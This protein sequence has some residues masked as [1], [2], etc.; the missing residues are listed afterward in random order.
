M[1]LASAAASAPAQEPATTPAAVAA[2]AAAPLTLDDVLRRVLATSPD[3]EAARRAVDAARAGVG[4]AAQI[5]NPDLTLEEAKETP[6]DAAT[7]SFPLE[8][9]GKRSERVHVAEAEA[10]VAEAELL[11]ATADARQAARR[12]FFGLAAAQR[13]AALRQEQLALATRVRDAA[14]ERYE[15]GDRPRLD[16]VEAQLVLAAAGAED[17]AARGDVEGARATLAVLLGE[18]ADAPLAVAADFAPAPLPPRQELA[19]AAMAT[20]G[21]VARLTREVEAQRS[22]VALARA[23][24]FPDLTVAGGV[25]HD[26][27]PDFLWGWRAALTVGVPLFHHNQ[28]QVEVEERTLAQREAELDAARRRVEGALASGIALVEATARTASRYRDEVLPQSQEV[29]SMAEDSYRSGETGVENL[30]A[31]LRAARDTRIQAIQAEL[32][33][34]NALADLEQVLGAPLP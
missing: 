28:H 26:S 18:P 10:R 19:T 23:E 12:A 30:L 33:Y 29:E 5:P 21:E 11:R 25:T 16:L 27:P 15:T 32:E 17:D 14:K 24:Q 9:G 2:P 34:E 31:V 7:M 4:V 6:H 8:V 22:R 20:S 13:E 1:S 3:V